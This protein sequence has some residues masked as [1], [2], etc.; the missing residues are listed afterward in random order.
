VFIFFF[1][2]RVKE[3]FYLRHVTI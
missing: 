2:F 3:E 1:H